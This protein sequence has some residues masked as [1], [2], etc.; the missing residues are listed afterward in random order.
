[1]TKAT[2]RIIIVLA[3]VCCA[4]ALI[5]A[6]HLPD[7]DNRLE[8]GNVTPAG[9]PTESNPP[10]G[11]NRNTT[12]NKVSEEV[13]EVKNMTSKGIWERAQEIHASWYRS[14]T[15]ERVLKEANMTPDELPD[16]VTEELKNIVSF[17][18]IIEKWEFDSQTK[19]VVIHASLSQN[20]QHEK[21]LSAVS[22]RQVGGW[23]F[24]V[25]WEPYVPELMKRALKE[26]NMTLEELPEEVKEEMDRVQLADIRTW[27]LDPQNNQVIVHTYFSR[28]EKHEKEV[29][30]V[31][32]REVAGWTFNVVQEYYVPEDVRQALKEANMTAEELPE[33]VREEIEH[34][35][36]YKNREFIIMRW[37]FDSEDKLV[38]IRAFSIQDEKKVKAIQGKQ[39]GGWTFTVIH[40][41]EYEK[42]YKKEFEQLG[43]EL[44]QFQKDHPELQIS[45]FV[46]SP[47]EIEIWVRNLTPENEAL[48][49]TVMHNRTV[50]IN[51]NAI[52]YAIRVAR[53]EAR[54]PGTG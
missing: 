40:D 49:G 41:P 27:E 18:D 38:I 1:M 8:T 28:D 51:W 43:A 21:E 29:K 2:P 6:V 32:G 17:E 20:E 37:E 42:E 3:I 48:N 19:Q 53:E 10:G 54:E 36:P 14:R 25:V 13:P 5:V 11:I 50:L 44:V 26:A 7:G 45:G 9:S 24:N 35:R 4:G 12:L 16:D 46:T 15:V 23:T 34:L 33:E 31:Q 39:V 30:A 52:D 22:G 47:T